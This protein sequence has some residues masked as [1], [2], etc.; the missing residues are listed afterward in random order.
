MAEIILLNGPP[1]SGKSEAARLLGK[2]FNK[3]KI[4]VS[5]EK[6]AAPLDII[7][8]AILGMPANVF[9]HY[10]E[11]LKDAE[12]PSQYAGEWRGYSMRQLLIMISEDWV[13]PLFGEDHFG[14]VAA[15]LINQKSDIVYIFSDSG[16]QIEYNRLKAEL[17]GAVEMDIIQMHRAGKGFANDSRQWVTDAE[18]G[19]SMLTNN[20]TLEVLE[21]RL[22]SYVGERGTEL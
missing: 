8:N 22:R 10:R 14:R 16:F 19:H 5:H 18:G 21:A 2:V 12:L 9:L 3:K 1:R 20:S 15:K 13:K 4:V 17:G 6:F 7:A 11:T